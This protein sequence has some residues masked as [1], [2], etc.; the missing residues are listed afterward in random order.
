MQ[1]MST[2]AR[3]GKAA[4]APSPHQDA[5][6]STRMRREKIRFKRQP[7]V[8]IFRMADPPNALLG[9]H[10]YDLRAPGSAG[11]QHA[12]SPTLGGVPSLTFGEKIRFSRRPVAAT[13]QRTSPSCTALE[14]CIQTI[15]AQGRER[16]LR[17]P[18]SLTS[19]H[20]HIRVGK[21]YALNGGK[22]Q[23]PC[24]S[25]APPPAPYV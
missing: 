1:V 23:A 14:V 7:V 4:H 5:F 15:Q 13:L 9:V 6:Q 19:K 20:A 22:L 11:G 12:H 16:L 10:M 24:A 17:I 3:C 2:P 25:P 8:V 18:C 21:R